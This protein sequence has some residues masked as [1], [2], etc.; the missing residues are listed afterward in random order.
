MPQIS[1]N[2]PQ[3]YQS[4][5]TILRQRLILQ[6]QTSRSLNTSR[7]LLKVLTGKNIKI[8]MTGKNPGNVVGGH[9]ATISDPRLSPLSPIFLYMVF[10]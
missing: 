7:P 8:D 3:L 1:I 5:S 9:K 4:S 2:L 6:T 10:M